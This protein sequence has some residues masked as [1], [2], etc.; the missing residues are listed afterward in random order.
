MAC[1]FDGSSYAAL[2]LQAVACDPARQQFALF[3]DELEQEVR[4]FVINVLDAEFAETAIFFTTQPEFRVAE[5]LD[6][7]SGSSHSIVWMSDW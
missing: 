1:T 7:F 5:E 6:I 3:I 2:V 4:I